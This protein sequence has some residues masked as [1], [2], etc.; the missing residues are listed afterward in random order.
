MLFISKLTNKLVKEYANNEYS[1]CFNIFIL[2]CLMHSYVVS[3]I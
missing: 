2:G 1:I 3:I